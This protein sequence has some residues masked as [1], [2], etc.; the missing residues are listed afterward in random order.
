LPTE[1][2]ATTVD[3]LKAASSE[4]GGFPWASAASCRDKA[5]Q[6]L[7]SGYDAHHCGIDAM[8]RFARKLQHDL[9]AVQNTLTTRWSNGQAEGR[10]AD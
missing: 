5:P 9:D 10:S 1:R 8:Q 2:Q 4:C 7:A 6:R 3:A